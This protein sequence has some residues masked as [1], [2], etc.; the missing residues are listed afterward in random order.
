MPDVRES[1]SP[2]RL[3]DASATL[4]PADRALLDL[5]VN[6]GLDDDELAGLSHLSVGVIT[7]RRHSII[8][9]LSADLELSPEHVSE[10]LRQLAATSPEPVAGSPPP[11]H[12]MT[13]AADTEARPA[14]ET[15]APAAETPPAAETWAPAA[16]TPPAAET[17]A[18][19][20]ETRRGRRRGPL[21]AVGVVFVAVLV[22]GRR[23]AQ[24]RRWG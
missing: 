16:E 7:A 8:E 4:D 11:P 14:A 1:V 13:P 5:W 22:R 20:A 24:H 10:S 21:I 15:W 2:T 19:A 23:R 12:S 6:R 9:R 3:I 17:R 18:P